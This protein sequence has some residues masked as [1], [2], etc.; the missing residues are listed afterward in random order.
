MTAFILLAG[1]CDSDEQD[2]TCQS[3][4]EEHAEQQGEAVEELCN[5]D[6]EDSAAG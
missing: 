4:Q 6:L 3:I 2:T 5:T 1:S